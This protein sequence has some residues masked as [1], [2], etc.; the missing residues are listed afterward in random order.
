M[1]VILMGPPGAGKG[2]QAEA[3]VEHY[4]LTHIS[5]GEMFRNAAAEGTEQGLKAKEFM[6]KGQLVPDD[7]TIGVVRERILK[8]DCLRG[9]MLD[10]FPRTIAQA[11]ALDT[12]LQDLGR[13]IDAVL[14]FDVPTEEL[15]KRLTGRML[16]RKCGAA[17]HVRNIPSKVEG[18][19]DKCGGEL[20]VRED[21]KEETVWN[22]LSVYLNQTSPLIEYY[23]ESSRLSGLN[24]L[25]TV[26]EVWTQIQEV[27]ANLV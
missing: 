19:C 17:F 4:G 13:K 20:Y 15:V 16:C 27:L 7:V 25:G 8:P 21:D 6:D 10:G 12:M 3:I 24:G 1:I 22:R 9:C 11:E 26:E 5:T 23:S 2:T 18:I 14:Y